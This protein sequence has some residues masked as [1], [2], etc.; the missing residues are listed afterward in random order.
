MHNRV[1]HFYLV[2]PRQEHPYQNSLIQAYFSD[3]LINSK[4]YTTI[5][6]EKK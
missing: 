1:V 5:S 3:N 2:F 6:I 4:G